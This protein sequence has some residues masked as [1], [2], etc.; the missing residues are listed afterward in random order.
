LSGMSREEAPGR[1][2]QKEY[3]EG[4]TMEY[5]TRFKMEL[6]AL[7]GRMMGEKVRIVSAKS[8]SSDEAIGRPD[9]TDFPLLKGREVLMEAVFRGSRGHA[10]TDMPGEFQGTLRDIAG[11]ALKTN[12]ERALFIA[13]LNAVM[14]DAGRASNTVHCRD[15][16]PRECARRLPAFVSGRFGR[17]RIA[18]VGYQPAMIEELS[19]SFAL[20]V[21]DLDQQNI[22]GERFGLTIEGPENTGDILSWGDIILAT[23]S[24]C[25]NGTI[26]SFLNRKPVV[27]YGVTVA[28]P[29]AIHGY[30]RFCP[31]S[32]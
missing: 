5:Y 18:F 28:G 13:A 23:G 7:A 27:F 32:G 21:V 10:F 31:C 29:A 1:H 25:V 6:S 15:K 24:T 22:G 30:D 8:L 16:A 9:R 26:T 14:R 12:F 17:P 20:R 11:L 2:F 19:K 4:G 3:K